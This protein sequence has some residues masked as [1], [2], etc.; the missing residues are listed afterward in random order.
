ML[1]GLSAGLLLWTNGRMA[2]ISGIVAGG[3][4]PAA[5]GRACILG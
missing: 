2:G 4:G 3:I 5:T 1:I